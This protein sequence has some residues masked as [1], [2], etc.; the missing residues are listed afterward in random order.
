MKKLITVLGCLLIVTAGASAQQKNFIDVPY[1]EANGEADSLVVP[2]E[3]FIKIVISEKDTRDKIPLEETEN[4]MIIAMKGMRI[5]VEKD[6]TVSD[7]L[8]NYRFYLLKQKDIL[9]SKE[10]LLKVTDATTASN[11]FIQLENLGI[12][13]TQIDHV[14][15]TELEAIGNIC[16][17]RAILNAKNRA[18]AL[19]TPLNQSVGTAIHVSDQNAPQMVPLQ[20]QGQLAGVIVSGYGYGKYKAEEPPKIDFKKIKV[21]A[22]VQVKFRIINGRE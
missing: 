16:R 6:L 11:V 15:H 8:S 2:N 4:K 14:N 7:M 21:N 9:K 17:S 13:N 22:M 19:L 5:N 3:I 12:S 1:V 10:Y 18:Q 20:Y